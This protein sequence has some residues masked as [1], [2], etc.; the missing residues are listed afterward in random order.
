MSDNDSP[1][2]SIEKP[3]SISQFFPLIVVSPWAIHLSSFVIGDFVRAEKMHE[4][5]FGVVP[6]IQSLCSRYLKAASAEK[7]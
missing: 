6:G 2:L 4:E 3:R 1:G 7:H 5:A